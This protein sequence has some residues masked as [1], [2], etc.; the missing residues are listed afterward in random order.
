M[1]NQ[2][3]RIYKLTMIVGIGAGMAGLSAPALAQDFYAGKTTEIIVGGEPGGGYDL[4]SRA[5]AQ[6]MPKYI[7][8]SPTII[9]RNMPGAGS[10]VAA[11][12]VYSVAAKDGTV[13]GS[14]FPAAI[15]GPLF[16]G[17]PRPYDPNAFVYVG[18]AD[19]GARVCATYENSPVASFEQAIEQPVNIGASFAGGNT[20]EYANMHKKA[21]GA[22]FNVIGGYQGTVDIALA[23]ERGEV[24]GLCGWPWASVKSQ[25]PEWLA[26]NKLNVILQVNPTPDPELTEMGVPDFFDFVSAD[27]RP[28]VELI[29]SQQ[30]F[31]RPYVLAPETPADRVEIIRAAFDA[32]M[33]DEAFLAD[34]EKMRLDISPSTGT[35]VQDMVTN[36]YA[37]SGPVLER[38]RELIAP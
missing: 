35:E 20:A 2:N 31:G 15:A 3:G 13:I 21:A 22:Q 7:P 36:M 25:Q 19:A 8:G 32:T 27:D 34:A 29:V 4:Y 9:V 6:H 33:A 5:I 1:H 17:N 24:D 23:M 28:A 37:A 14:I 12:H 10:A 18:S 16:D 11:A 38:A 26:Q 30:V